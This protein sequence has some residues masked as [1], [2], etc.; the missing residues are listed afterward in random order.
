MF[1]GFFLRRIV[2]VTLCGL[3]F[4]A[5]M[6]TERLIIRSPAAATAAAACSAKDGDAR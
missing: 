3:A 6:R 5:G 2:T 1:F 4:W